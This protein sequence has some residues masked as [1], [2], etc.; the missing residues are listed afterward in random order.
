MSRPAPRGLRFGLLAGGVA[1][2]AGAF[3]LLATRPEP[4]TVS[5]AGEEGA[6]RSVEIRPVHPLEVRQRAELAGVLEARRSVRLVAET[7]GRVLEV[8]AEALDVVEADQLLLR[9]DPLLAEVAV[10]RAEAELARRSSEHRLAEANLERRRSLSEREV[11]SDAMLDDAENAARVAAAALREAHARLREARD[12]LAK[13]TVLAPFAGVLRSFPVEVGESIRNGQELGELLDVSSAR[14]TVGLAD[15]QIVHVEPEQSVDVVVEALPNRTF[16]GTI[17]RVGRAA[18]ARTKKFPVEVELL[19]ADG[20]LLPGMVVRVVLELE[21]PRPRLVVP[22][23]ATVDEF[24]LRSVYV[25]EPS[26]ETGVGVVERRRV[27]VRPLPFRPADLE[28]VSGLAAGEAIAVTGVR[29][30]E[31]GERVRVRRGG[32]T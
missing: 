15:H 27:H 6:L 5:A 3:L 29:Q 8:G 1:L 24:G 30:L 9:V 32:S 23:D 20:S 12:A 16:A 10:E 11:V 21:A 7:E 31:D 2:L 4:D 19:N 25:V 13:K 28:V 26:E 17:L 14:T 18:D 22:R